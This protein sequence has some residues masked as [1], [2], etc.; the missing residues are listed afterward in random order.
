MT[1]KLEAVR[2]MLKELGVEVPKLMIIYTHRQQWHD[3]HRLKSNFHI[4]LKHL[5]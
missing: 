2:L 5:K 1:Q 3:V 4:K